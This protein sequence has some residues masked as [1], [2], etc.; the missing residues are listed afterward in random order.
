[1]L[2]AA[3]SQNVDPVG[4]ILG[5]LLFAVGVAVYMIPT[6]VAWSQKA[7]DFGIV[8]VVNVLLG[9]T[10]IGW[11]VALVLALRQP[12]QPAVVVVPQVTAAPGWY[13]QADGSQRW[14]DGTSWR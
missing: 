14:W 8:A 13:G 2:A 3:Q 11:V 5:V 6:L 7:P 4:V 1:M 9:W 12:R 10:F